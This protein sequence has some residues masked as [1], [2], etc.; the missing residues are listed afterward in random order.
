MKR[1]IPILWLTIAAAT[2]LLAACH[3][4]W[5]KASRQPIAMVRTL[6]KDLHYRQQELEKLISD[7]ALMQR[8]IKNRLTEEDTR[9]MIGK[10]FVI[11]VFHKKQLVFWNTNKTPG[12]ADH[13]TAT[14][15][16]YIQN[17]NV[18]LAQRLSI[19][20]DS[21]VYAHI[22]IPVYWYYD[23]SNQYLSSY[24]VASRD[25]PPKAEVSLAPNG[26]NIPLHTRDG[27]TVCYIDISKADIGLPVP[28][29]IL[30]TLC[31]LAVISSAAAIH[32]TAFFLSSRYRPATG[33]LFLALVILATRMLNYRFGLPF[34]L[35]EQ[36]LFSPQI[37]ASS[38]FLPSFGDLMI[39]SLMIYW[40]LAFFSI[41]SLREKQPDPLR[42]SR[43]LRWS[44]FIAIG[45]LT[46]SFGVYILYLIQTLVMDSDISFDTNSLNITDT[47]TLLVF[48]TI[49]LQIRIF[50]I[51][52][53]LADIW[54]NRFVRDSLPKYMALILISLFIIFIARKL[55]MPASPWSPSLMED[56][57]YLTAFLLGICFLFL[58]NNKYSSKVFSD[59]GMFTAILHSV[60]W[61]L[62]CAVFFQYDIAQHERYVSRL[63]FAEKLSRQQD[64]DMEVI[65]P[66]IA[67]KIK[68]D[69]VI[70]S[71]LTRKDTILQN[72]IQQ[73]FEL[74]YTESTLSNYSGD[75]YLYNAARQ[76]LTGDNTPDY[77]TI[78]RHQLAAIPTISENLF[79]HLDPEG[80]NYY[81][82]HIPIRQQGTD[83]VTGYLC[84]E[85]Q[86]RKNIVSTLYPQLLQ[87]NA[88]TRKRK[89][90]AY[91]YAIYKSGILKSQSGNHSFRMN[92]G[93]APGNHN[94][95]F[96][97]QSDVSELY[98]RGNEDMVFVVAYQNAF[99]LGV[100]TIF[101][102]LFGIYMIFYTLEIRLIRTAS[103]LISGKR[104]RL[105]YKAS[106]GARIK[107][108]ALGFIIISFLTIGIS[109]V[110]FLRNR[111][112]SNNV[113]LLEQSVANVSE[114]LN[115]YLDKT[116]TWLTAANFREKTAEADFIYFISELARQY[117]HDIN[118]FDKEGLLALSTR[119]SIYDKRILE[120]HMEPF[121]YF[122][123]ADKQQY[124]FL[125]SEKIGGL[126]FISAYTTI[127]NREDK[128]VGYLNLPSFDAQKALNNQITTLLTTLI[129]IYTLLLLFSSTII[130][131]FINS[132]TRSLRLVSDSLK[133]VNL[134]K[135]ELIDWPY[136]DEIG[137][138][139][140][141]YNKMVTTVEKNA[142]MLVKDERHN[143]WREMAKQVA[144]EIKNPLTPMKLNIQ[145]LQQAIAQN[146]PDITSM[147]KRVSASIIEQIDN[148][149][150]IASEFSNFAKMPEQHVEHIDLIALLQSIVALYEGKSTE[151][152]LR[153]PKDQ[154]TL[155]IPSDK[156]QT[157]RIFTNLIQNGAD[158]IPKNRKGRVDIDIV[159][160]TAW[161]NIL[162]TITDNG[163]G[164]EESIKDKIF[165]PY[166]TTKTSGTGLGLAMTKKIIE[167]WDGEIWFESEAGNGTTFFIVL[168]YEGNPEI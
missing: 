69:S 42:L 2:W 16:I 74:T 24:F 118:I 62:I 73:H 150:Y 50:I 130:F 140:A 7:Q 129:N 142:E 126:S 122:Q 77:D 25:I 65:F 102:F 60:Y 104:I 93:K 19:T 148:L 29:K 44:I 47:F 159:L 66:D 165:E 138:L 100:L 146:H 155:I 141:E 46:G 17:K 117:K 85:V 80:N 76:P 108:F 101:S 166:F 132:L 20:G 15:G 158:A 128:V 144:H 18:F 8:L 127:V 39:N 125:Q 162:I 23:I 6:E 53:Q 72:E 113:H 3:F 123:L 103:L 133:N 156:S 160:N 30:L 4:N 38:A 139:V 43:W 51:A 124:R 33:I 112:K 151:V 13:A 14:P 81:I 92:I 84:A 83:S 68:G 86:L 163:I 5:Q 31:L 152:T 71:W 26:T 21:N 41:Q 109:T 115:H 111:Y 157:L 94:Y 99:S 12:T 168:P 1:K 45:F 106:L 136:E 28:D 105:V 149:N 70:L 97:D 78:N 90:P 121:A 52:L 37:F 167:L 48:V 145:Y 79:F 27:S 114:M 116:D 36:K 135:N 131:F 119:N 96:Y 9:S 67:G 10:P 40:F 88:V 161:N 32:L 147:V 98:F 82:I 137:L 55:I 164:I 91:N 35:G 56:L 64:T 75:I 143:A 110:L 87:D 11:R 153:T 63:S 59:R 57:L 34:H 107:Y 54:M 58:K 49:A 134:Q 120:Q 61:S 95:S 22:I 89:I 154:G